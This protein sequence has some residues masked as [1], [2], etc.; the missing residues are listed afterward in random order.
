M[1]ELSTRTGEKSP[2]T[3]LAR[4]DSSIGDVDFFGRAPRN[5]NRSA[6]DFANS[7]SGTEDD[8]ASV[9]ALSFY[10]DQRAS[11]SRLQLVPQQSLLLYKIQ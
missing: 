3:N 11:A 1:T 5:P 8:F 4:S 7:E 2:E 9:V 10:R 6:Y